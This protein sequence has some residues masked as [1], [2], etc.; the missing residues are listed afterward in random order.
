MRMVPGRD[1]AQA[2][3]RHRT[4]RKGGRPQ[5]YRTDRERRTAE[6]RQNAIRQQAFRQ[7]L[8]VTENPPVNDS[9]HVGSKGQNRP[10]AIPIA[11]ERE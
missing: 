5:K 6:R 4:I 3:E 11:A 8:N 1:G 2:A 7:R 9:F 10:L